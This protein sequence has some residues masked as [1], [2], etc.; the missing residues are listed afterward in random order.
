MPIRLFVGNLPYDVTEAELREF[1]SA[2][3][4]L[5]Y[6]YLPTDR[7]T[8]KLR[9]FAF[10]EFND[11]AHTEEAIRS[12]NNLMFKGRPL[13]VKEA[14]VKEDRPR[15]GASSRSS[16]PRPNPTA[17]PNTA[18]LPTHGGEMDRGFGSDVAPRRSRSKAKSGPKSERGPKGPMREVA[19]GRFFGGDEEDSYDDESSGENF[20]SRVSDS[21]GEGDV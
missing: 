7:E 9:G 6:V 21:E 2:V 5:S 12:F 20:A 10:I 8:G 4:P 3:G 19:R 14:R 17:K 15:A 18:G 16:L 1:F 11:R 13:V